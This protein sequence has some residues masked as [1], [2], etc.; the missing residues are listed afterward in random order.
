MLY[1]HDHIKIDL[2]DKNHSRTET[3]IINALCNNK[4][5]YALLKKE[6]EVVLHILDY[7][8][9]GAI[10]IPILF[11]TFAGNKNQLIVLNDKAP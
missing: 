5:H 3:T 11:S 10:F 9:L 1:L 6:Y 4:I 8:T 2:S 7:G